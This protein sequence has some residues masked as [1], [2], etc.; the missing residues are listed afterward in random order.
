[1]IK[2]N[3]ENPQNMLTG[4][5]PGVRVWQRTAEPGE[6]A[7]SMDIRGMGSPLVVIDGVPREMSDFQRLSPTDIENVSV[8]KDAAA[9]IYGLR[10]GNG[11]ILVTTKTGKAGKTRVNYDGSYTF[12][13]PA[14]LPRQM[15]AIRSMQLVNERNRGGIEG[16]APEFPDELIDR[17]ISG[18]LQG[19][20][21]NSLISQN[22]APQTRH[23]LSISGCTDESQVC[24]GMGDF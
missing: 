14:S 3:T 12:Q 2:T 1:M 6:Y 15:D 11:V 24:V 18:E 16:G 21:W 13:T 4:R 8:L 9:A 22:M 5:V 19:T 7:A 17:Y 23:E 20:D 10:G